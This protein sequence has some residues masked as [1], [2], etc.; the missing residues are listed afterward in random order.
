[1][2]AGSYS[3]MGVLRPL[4]LVPSRSPL[5]SVQVSVMTPATPHGSP[6]L[7][8][9][10]ACPCSSNLSLPTSVAST[11]HTALHTS[12][13]FGSSV[14]ARMPEWSGGNRKEP[15]YSVT[16]RR[17]PRGGRRPLQS[18]TQPTHISRAKSGWTS[19]LGPGARERKKG[20]GVD[21]RPRS[22]PPTARGGSVSYRGVFTQLAERGEG[23]LVGF[24][25]LLCEVVQ[26]SRHFIAFCTFLL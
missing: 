14:N 7:P 16:A 5:G 10:T 21:T 1:M 4:P 15:S 22:H 13:R 26:L 23:F 19:S 18:P 20:A 3:W 9:Q 6:G 12:V 8:H 11:S 17:L 24:A 2:L 25:D